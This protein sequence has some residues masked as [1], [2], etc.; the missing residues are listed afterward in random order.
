MKQ[1]RFTAMPITSVALLLMIMMVGGS[2]GRLSRSNM[3]PAAVHTTPAAF[4]IKINTASARE[5]E[6]LPGVGKVIAEH[7]VAYREQY[8][9]FRRPE[10]LLMVNGISDRK[11]RAIQ[12]LIV[13][14]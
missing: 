10:E 14:E 12:A 3:A 8:G 7:I 11:F 5:L 1:F 6:Q 13:V 2:C 4:Q 9:R